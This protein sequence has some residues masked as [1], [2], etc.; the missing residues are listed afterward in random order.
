MEFSRL[1]GYVCLF[2][3]LGMLTFGLVLV[4][5]GGWFYD[6]LEKTRISNPK[7]Y[8]G[9]KLTL[10]MN[11]PL[12][13]FVVSLGIFGCLAFVV[14]GV[15]NP[16]LGVAGILLLFPWLWLTIRWTKWAWKK[17]EVQPNGA[18]SDSTGRNPE[19]R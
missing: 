9:I 4:E 16:W 17:D 11:G 14:R 12:T 1:A 15:A 2:L 18:D 8:E 19:S 3:F 13:V 7:R 5:L 10:R 6:D